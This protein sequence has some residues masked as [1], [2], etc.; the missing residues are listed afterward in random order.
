MPCVVRLDRRTD[1]PRHRGL[2]ART[3]TTTAWDP[4]PGSDGADALPR[5]DTMAVSGSTV[6]VGAG[7]D[8]IGGERRRGI[9]ALDGSHRQRHHVEPRP[10]R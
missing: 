8:S 6:Y 10:R 9:A 2:D 5:I 7:F 3:G 4:N 1:P